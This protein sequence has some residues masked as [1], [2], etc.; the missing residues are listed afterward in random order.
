MW[1]WPTWSALPRGSCKNRPSSLLQRDRRQTWPES[2]GSRRIAGP[3]ASSLTILHVQVESDPCARI[4]L[5]LEE[6]F[7]FCKHG[8]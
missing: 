2:K 5:S 8:K 7:L 6:S 1:I 3:E 4:P